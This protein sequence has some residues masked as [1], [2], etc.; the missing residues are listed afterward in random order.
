MYSFLIN[1]FFVYVFVITRRSPTYNQ[2]VCKVKKSMG[3]GTGTSDVYK[4]KLVWFSIA[5]SFLRQ[6]LQENDS[7]SNLVKMLLFHFV[8][9]IIHTKLL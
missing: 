8:I 4:P 1:T 6:N 2:E 9:L 7:E 3:T 5:D